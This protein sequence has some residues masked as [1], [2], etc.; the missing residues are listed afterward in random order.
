VTS[1]YGRQLEFGLF[2]VPN[3]DDLEVVRSLARRADELGLDLIG[4]QDHPYLWRS[5]RPG[6]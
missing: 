1:R 4:I 3:A 2:P 5:W 6:R